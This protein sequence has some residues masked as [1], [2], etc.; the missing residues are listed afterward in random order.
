MTDGDE[1]HKPAFRLFE[2]GSYDACLDLIKKAGPVRDSSLRVL[3]AL[4][5][6]S[7][8]RIDEA[9]VC[10]RD[11]RRILPDSAEV[12]LYLGRVLEEKGDESARAEFCEAVRLDPN[13]LAALRRYAAYLVAEGDDE[14][15]YPVI[16]LL[17]ERF[18]DPQDVALLLD[19]L[20]RSGRY[21]EAAGLFTPESIPAGSLPQYLHALNA[22]GRDEEVLSIV[23]DTGFSDDKI[24]VWYIRSLSRTDPGAAE[25]FLLADPVRLKKPPVAGEFLFFLLSAGRYQEAAGVYHSYLSDTADPRDI[26]NG[27]VACFE[28]GDHERAES[29]CRRVLF[30]QSSPTD[31]DIH[32]GITSLYSRIMEMRSPGE[33]WRLLLNQLVMAADTVSLVSAADIAA[34]NGDDTMARDLYFRAFRS[35]LIL[36]GSA[37]AGYLRKKG[38]IHEYRKI[39]MYMI[40]TVRKIRDLEMITGMILDHQ[41]DPDI[42]ELLAERFRSMSHLLST[43][44]RTYYGRILLSLSVHARETG[45]GQAGELLCIEAL[46]VLPADVGEVG[47]ALFHELMLCKKSCFSLPV[48]R[49]TSPGESLPRR[50]MENLIPSGLDPVEESV[51]LYL[52]RHQICSE[53]EL[54]KVAGTNRVAGLIN[55][56]IRKLSDQGIRLIEKDGFG[57][58]GE[59]YRYAG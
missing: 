46:S 17:C 27:A 15:A 4:C 38:D 30:E 43:R 58:S 22:L 33:G 3:E 23:Q 20:V 8:S 26:W 37:Y 36:G 12:C 57:E 53:T 40:R 59:V 21:T 24:L 11:L 49:S 10:L 52:A 25:R 51:L 44:G 50:S 9:E 16:A 29:L 5:L 45:S 47:D 35:D 32:A 28:A 34:D 31:W 14:G 56:I 41:P 55:R 54:R 6:I 13:G 39:L 19:L 1:L 18:Q 7:V 48:R 42:L 2:Q